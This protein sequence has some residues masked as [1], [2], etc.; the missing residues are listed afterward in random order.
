M[1]THSSSPVTRRDLGLA[2]LGVLLLLLAWALRT[3]LMLIAFA[4]LFAFILDPL[5]S[6]LERP[7][8]RG[9]HLPRGIAA[10]IVIL[11]LVVLIGSI[12]SIGMPLLL[13]Q[14][15]EFAARLPGQIERIM[16]ELRTRAAG[17]GWAEEVD[18]A[19]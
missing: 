3:I 6:G 4:M 9:R 11:A 1:T 5:V 13:R 7:A 2:L 14:L 19:F 10:V 12:A 8:L 17:T 15:V 16:D 18:P